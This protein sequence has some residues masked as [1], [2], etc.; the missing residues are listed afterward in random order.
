MAKSLF[1]S[2]VSKAK[3]Y[4][5]TTTHRD[6]DKARR[7]IA[8]LFDEEEMDFFMSDG[9]LRD[10]L[11]DQIERAFESMP[12]VKKDPQKPFIP[13]TEGMQGVLDAR[14]K[15]R[16][17]INTEVPKPPV[18]DA[19]DRD[20][21]KIDL[22]TAFAEST[23]QPQR[24]REAPDFDNREDALK[25]IRT[26]MPMKFDAAVFANSEEAPTL[27]QMKV[28]MQKSLAEAI[29]LNDKENI[30]KLNQA[31]DQ[32]DLMR[33]IENNPD[34]INKDGSI[35][36]EE[37]D[38]INNRGVV[39]LL[40]GVYKRSKR[41]PLLSMDASV[42]E[43]IA[44]EFSTGRKAD[45]KL[46]A[47]VGAAVDVFS[48]PGR[49]L[50][51][52]DDMWN[53]GD[54]K[55]LSGRWQTFLNSLAINSE[56]RT[57]GERALFEAT[58]LGRVTPLKQFGN[59][60]VSK[61][62]GKLG[63]TGRSIQKGMTGTRAASIKDPLFRAEELAL[64]KAGKK[65]Y[66]KWQAER[67]K[68]YAKE[69]GTTQL[70]KEIG[71]NLVNDGANILLAGLKNEG[72]LSDEIIGA[73][74]GNFLG[75]FFRSMTLDKS[76]KRSLGNKIRESGVIHEGDLEDFNYIWN[77]RKGTTSSFNDN[78]KD[79]YEI[80]DFLEKVSLME[81]REIEKLLKNKTIS[82]KDIEKSL[83]ALEKNFKSSAEKDM[84]KKAKQVTKKII[85]FA[86]SERGYK[87]V[88]NPEYFTGPTSKKREQD[89]LAQKRSISRKIQEE[90]RSLR[91]DLGT[92]FDQYKKEV[93]EVSQAEENLRSRIASQK[94][95]NPGTSR[96]GLEAELEAIE[97]P[98]RPTLDKSQVSDIR[99]RGTLEGSTPKVPARQIKEYDPDIPAE[100]V[101]DEKVAQGRYGYKSQVQD[102]NDLV[103]E[104]RMASTKLNNLL[105]EQIPGYSEQ[106]DELSSAIEESG[107]LQSAN[108]LRQGVAPAKEIEELQR[109][110]EAG[111]F[112][113]GGAMKPK[114]EYIKRVSDLVTKAKQKVSDDIFKKLSPFI[115]SK[116]LTKE[117]F[118]EIV[119]AFN[120]D[121][122]FDI[123]NVDSA[124]NKLRSSETKDGLI[125]V[126]RSDI[127]KVRKD[128][129]GFFKKEINNIDRWKGD[130]ITKYVID[131]A[132]KNPNNISGM[133]KSFKRG[134]KNM[135]VGI[136][137]GNSSA[138]S[139]GAG[140]AS[141]GVVNK[142]KRFA[143][144]T[145]I[146]S[147]S[148]LLG[149][150][151]IVPMTS[152]RDVFL[153]DEE[154]L[155]DGPPPKSFQWEKEWGDEGYIQSI[156][157]TL[158]RKKFN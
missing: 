131:Q 11:G 72:A 10:D 45:S 66:F 51:A 120:L 31:I 33:I 122:I 41:L 157:D 151:T 35:N 113:K 137:A 103:Q 14:E 64:S 142:S 74:T 68:Q 90:L 18:V 36:E 149:Y 158:S 125:L 128:I 153:E 43:A 56:D 54:R 135:L 50:S 102:A 55:D 84:A 112:T 7:E 132:F 80:S 71:D 108:R 8:S 65:G 28:N 99:S 140:D 39:S 155:E 119:E 136:T 109:L 154:S 138:F 105:K 79:L 3:S 97:Y 82:L 127:K 44:P 115:K 91:E 58:T 118:K 27:G 92:R 46:Q 57:L 29:K 96:S 1:D 144:S 139:R 5:D 62:V 156:P 100:K 22:P 15:G 123:K 75:A 63:Q 52:I 77:T 76:L 106:I 6:P 110:A 37:L 61:G 59:A 81:L 134:V 150:G 42:G 94:S 133:D 2:M 89:I 40:R 67:A 78:L 19:F 21:S 148:E 24:V 121:K 70:P 130:L 9:Q 111:A 25:A 126:K 95:L 129:D 53:Y 83:G 116:D 20:I 48:S 38:K 152:D 86:K 143:L 34:I 4:M 30:D 117:E 107:L 12:L 85:D 114:G 23:N 13:M 17:P 87:Y 141:R 26:Y 147:I 145:A 49:I 104:R 32:V 47:G 124:F 69:F 146:N 88:Y 16:A 101:Y 73:M 60:L 93:G 98:Q